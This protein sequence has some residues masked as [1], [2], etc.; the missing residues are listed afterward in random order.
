MRQATGR[1]IITAGS[2]TDMAYEDQSLE[3]EVFTHYLLKGLAGKAD[4]NRDGIVTTSE[5][6]EYLYS[7]VSEGSASK[8][9]YQRPSMWATESR[10]DFVLALVD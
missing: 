4:F 10:G 5:L 2:A 9:F 1:V 6:F 3:H 7:R 8:G